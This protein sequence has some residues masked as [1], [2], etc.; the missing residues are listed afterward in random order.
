[1]YRSFLTVFDSALSNYQF[2]WFDQ[3][4]DEFIKARAQ[5]YMLVMVI[6]FN[7][8][9]LNFIIAIFS[10]TFTKFEP[11][12]KG[13]YLSKIIWYRKEMEYDDRYGALI[14]TNA[15]LNFYMI[16]FLPFF[17]FMKDTR[18]IN[19]FLVAF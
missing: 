1:M 5:I 16:F 18:K 14:T 19:S 11:N 17:L 13:L 15:P 7:I 3:I 8:L 10:S 9:I 12:S 4:D 6:T 2:E